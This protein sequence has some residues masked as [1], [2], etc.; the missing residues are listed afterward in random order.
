MNFIYWNRG[1]YE[2]KNVNKILAV[3]DATYSMQLPKES[4]KTS[5][6]ILP[7]RCGIF[8]IFNPP[9]N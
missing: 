8:K 1:N 7:A 2:E 9:Y 6:L 3:E 4:L 5:G